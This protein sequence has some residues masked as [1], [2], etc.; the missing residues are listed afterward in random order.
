M[1]NL[2][3]HT[4][5]DKEFVKGGPY[6]WPGDIYEADNFLTL[7]TI[8]E[9]SSE[10]LKCDFYEEEDTEDVTERFKNATEWPLPYSLRCACDCWGTTLRNDSSK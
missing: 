3:L 5:E 6:A 1:K 2:S 4:V 9:S 7:C 10:C 8:I